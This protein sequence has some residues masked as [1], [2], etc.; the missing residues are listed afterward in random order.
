MNRPNLPTKR[1]QKIIEPSSDTLRPATVDT[2]EPAAE[3]PRVEFTATPQPTPPTDASNNQPL[4]PTADKSLTPEQQ[5]T[6]DHYVSNRPDS[7]RQPS[8]R[9]E[10]TLTIITVILIILPALNILA[11]ILTALKDPSEYANGMIIPA[12]LHPVVQLIF[13]IYLFKRNELARLIS[14][15]LIGLSLI[16]LTLATAYSLF[17]TVRLVAS[18]DILATNYLTIGLSHAPMLITYAAMVFIFFFLGRRD[19]RR[20][21]N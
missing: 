16:F 8:K 12:L 9:I 17:V 21:F 15:L 13:A 7:Q 10:H 3:A 1:T 19:V 18:D 2:P 5:A 4:P 11:T 20:L 14:R 6:Y